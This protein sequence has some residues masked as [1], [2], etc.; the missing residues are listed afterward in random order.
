[1]SA[2]RCAS[3]SKPASART[4]LPGSGNVASGGTAINFARVRGGFNLMDFGI[5]LLRSVVTFRSFPGLGLQGLLASAHACSAWAD[6]LSD[7][8]HALFR[9]RLIARAKSRLSLKRAYGVSPS[10]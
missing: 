7:V 2:R 4:G 3:T 1:M 9:R 6:A 5:R 10:L 8:H